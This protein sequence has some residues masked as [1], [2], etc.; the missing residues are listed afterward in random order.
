M[1]G[2]PRLFRSYAH[3]RC[4]GMGFRRHGK[5]F[6]NEAAFVNGVIGSVRDWSAKAWRRMRRRVRNS[7][8]DGSNNSEQSTRISSAP[9]RVDITGLRLD[10]YRRALLRTS[11]GAGAARMHRPRPIPR[12]RGLALPRC[13]AV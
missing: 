10:I 11:R 1:L 5:L 13:S 3:T 4:L 8:M 7:D 6:A 9:P 12:T 2:S